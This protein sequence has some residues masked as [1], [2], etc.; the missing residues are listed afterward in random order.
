VLTD[1][2]F[3]AVVLRDAGH[4]GKGRWVLR[5]TAGELEAEL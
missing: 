1:E 3:V 2:Y 5:S 4:V